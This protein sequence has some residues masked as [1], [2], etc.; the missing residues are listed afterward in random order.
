KLLIP[1]RNTNPNNIT[2]EMYTFYGEISGGVDSLTTTNHVYEYNGLGYPIKMDN[3][4]T[5][6]YN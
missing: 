3:N 4:I 1:G 5:F 2:K 6:E